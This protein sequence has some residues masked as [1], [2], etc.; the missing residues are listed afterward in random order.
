ME[1]LPKITFY[2]C[3]IAAGGVM[4]GLSLGSSS[5]DGSYDMPLVLKIGVVTGCAG[6]GMVLGAGFGAIYPVSI[7]VACMIGFSR[8]REQKRIA[9]IYSKKY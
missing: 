5:L 9:K 7:P 8:C 4:G 3:M 1:A 6:F 2:R